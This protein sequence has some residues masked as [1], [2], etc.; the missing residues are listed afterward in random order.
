MLL[1]VEIL[2]LL[3]K[4]SL[5]QIAT[6]LQQKELKLKYLDETMLNGSLLYEVELS[7]KQMKVN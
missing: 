5:L 2:V 6:M 3:D 4:Q 7:L 1:L